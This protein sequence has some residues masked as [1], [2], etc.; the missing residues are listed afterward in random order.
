[1]P[2]YPWK[3]AVSGDAHPNPECPT[4][5][6]AELQLTRSYSL[7]SLLGIAI[8]AA[9][10]VGFYRHIAVE[11]LKT[12]ETSFNVAVAQSLSVT[13]WPHYAE[14]VREA[15]FMPLEALA[16]TP[17]FH[18]MRRE[19]TERMRGLRIL[20]VKIYDADGRIVFSSD[21]SQIGEAGVNKPAFAHTTAPTSELI[22]RSSSDDEIF[23]NIDVLSSYIPIHAQEGGVVD[24]GFEIF[25]DVTD[26]VKDIKRTSYLV[27]GGVT[28]LLL[29]L[30]VF[31]VAL[32]MRADRLIKRH[33]RDNQQR[34]QTRMEYLARYD[35]LTDLPNRSHFME[36]LSAA[37]TQAK[38][39]G[40][41]LGMIALSI[42]RFKLVNDSMGHEYG[43][44]AL[45]EFA[46]RLRDCIGTD[47]IIARLG[48]DQFAI[49][50]ASLGVPQLS[51]AHAEHI[52][53]R[54]AEL[55]QVNGRDI[56]LTTSL[57]LAAF[58]PAAQDAETLVENAIAAMRKAKR[59]GR[60]DFVFFTPE[61]GNRAHERLKLEMDLR[62]ALVDQQFVLHYQPRVDTHTG[63]VSS[64][65]AL[66]RWQHPQRGLLMP[67]DFISL[68]EDMDLVVPV[69]AWVLEQACQQVKAW[70]L[71]G[72]S[73][74]GVSVNVSLRQFR[75]ESLLESVR[76]ALTSSNLDAS[77][78]E[79][80]LTESVLADDI[81][82]AQA[83]ALELRALGVTIALDDFGTGYSSLSYLI[84]F[85]VSCLKI[86]RMFVTDLPHNT[87]HVAL[88]RAI[89]TMAN[90]LG[91][92]TV[93][94]GVENQAQHELLRD[95]GY[96]ETQGF[97]L[98]RPWV[99]DEVPEAI[100]NLQARP[101]LLAPSCA[102]PT[103]LTR[104]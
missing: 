8:I 55:M 18:A 99:A 56:V 15:G 74:L 90:G 38:R 84:H 29:L 33:E 64:V 87:R 72:H 22:Y 91:M 103:R 9:V 41:R 95:L 28:S 21:T 25:S 44:R 89:A 97:W 31:L 27:F 76:H 16:D 35:V 54:S 10:L 3:S 40:A 94:E 101:Q 45:I 51:K 79:L 88:A 102:A 75:A 13:L 39:T 63:T 78:L 32:V 58:G 47:A 80:E 83:I 81:A 7:R 93:A 50:D 37:I 2:R 62:R 4:R 96:T 5:M 100:D 68:I 11:N 24:G 53:E 14:F 49:M 48:G 60:N 34:Q 1:M 30:Y 26:M 57:G 70:Q 6:S 86:D 19:I 43:D 71:A 61:P 17:Q 85:P 36:L 65:E 73:N 46:R 59:L 69:G 23:K 52:V 67:N 98:G 66:L 77:A 92:S 20:K 104:R 42:D 82:K 12:Q